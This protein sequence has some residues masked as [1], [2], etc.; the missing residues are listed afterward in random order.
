[1]AEYRGLMVLSRR[2]SVWRRAG[3]AVAKRG[4][5]ALGSY[6][7]KKV[8]QK[9]SNNASRDN[10][11]N[12]SV[13]FQHDFDKQYS[14]RRAPRRVR[15]RAKRTLN[16]FNRTLVKTL[17]QRTAIFPQLYAS[18]PLTPTTLNNTQNVFD[19]G[20]YGGISG[21]ATWGGLASIAGSEGVLTKSGK[22]HFKSA[23]LDI[24]IKNF[25]TQVLLCDCYEVVAR[26]D[27]YNTPGA[28]WTLALTNLNVTPSGG[29][30]TPA[31]LGS[32]P[33]DAPGFGSSWLIKSKTRYRIGPENSIYLQLRDSRK[34]QFE[35][36]RFEYDTGAASIRVR[37]FAGL[38]KG[39]M[40]VFR[41]AFFDPATPKGGPIFYEMAY[42][43]TYH[44]AVQDSN[45]D[46]TGSY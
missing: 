39:Y 22:L 9:S 34:W 20:L 7:G 24:Q 30:V 12:R 3:F 13:T 38:T 46:L 31:M 1:M 19:V 18:G 42:S 41:S 21:S 44:Y 45:E 40:F 28:D 16:R 6:M 29:T 26:K 17:G 23:I 25:D 33:F 14:R 32:T 35:T 11:S 10:V 37:T 15:R 27:G 36:D 4:A 5:A 8:F 2:G 43:T